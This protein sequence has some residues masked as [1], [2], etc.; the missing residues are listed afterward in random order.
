MV[1]IKGID[2]SRH[3]GKIDWGK[4]KAQGND[5]AVIRA[6]YGGGV[7][8]EFATNWEGAKA[9]GLARGAY[10]FAYPSRS[11]GAQQAEEFFAIV[12]GLQA[13]DFIALDIEDEPSYGRSL[14]ATDVLWCLEF[15]NKCKELFGVKPLIY[16]NSSVKS[17]FDWSPVVAADY[18]LWVA[19]YGPNNGQQNAV[20][21]SAPWKFW[22]MW[23][24]TSKGSAGG[25][26]P[27]D[28]NVFQGD[29]NILAKYGAQSDSVFVAPPPPPTKP[30]PVPASTV[31]KYIVVPG[32]TLSKIAAKFSTTWQALAS[33]NGIADPNKIFA[34]QQ[35][36]VPNGVQAQTYVIQGGDTLGKIAAR[37]NT[38][39]QRLASIN[40]I[41]DP[42]KIY[43]GQVIRI[44]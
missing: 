27:V 21:D 2:V 35:L 38:T 41:S 5:F 1:M 11:S 14:V 34:G 39:V 3:N 16:M 43:K 23:Q 9:A 28:V 4:V 24:F 22:A 32:D 37:F 15:L 7:D 44:N 25:V 20:P 17:R 29:L 6:G 10:F 8:S 26:S 42:N 40:R 36:K 18:G 31:N 30:S 13:G 12:T 19:N 33:L